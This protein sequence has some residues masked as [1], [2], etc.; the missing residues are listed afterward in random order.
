MQQ[1]TGLSGFC[2]LSSSPQAENTDTVIAQ[3]RT[4]A[5]VIINFFIVL[6]INIL[7]D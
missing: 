6:S 5:N 1:A 4:A 7:C 3:Q 2:S